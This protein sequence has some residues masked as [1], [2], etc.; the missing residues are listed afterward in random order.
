MAKMK[1]YLFGKVRIECDQRE[2]TLESQK[3]LELFC[4]LLLNQRYPQHR[5]TLAEVLWGDGSANSK[6]YLRKT[7]W[8]L[9]NFLG[10]LQETDEENYLLVD[11][12][13]IQINP[14]I[15]IWLDTDVFEYA[16]S[17]TVGI[18]SFDFTPQQ[19]QSTQEAVELYQADL[20]LGWQGNW[21]IFERERFSQLY[22][23][24]VDKLMGYCEAGNRYERGIEYG[25]EILRHDQAHERTHRRLMRLYYLAGDRTEALRQFN[26]CREILMDELEVEPSDRTLALYQ[27]IAEQQDVPQS[28]SDEPNERAGFNITSKT[29]SHIDDILRKQF[30]NHI[31]LEKELQK[32]KRALHLADN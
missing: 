20:L 28:L 29:L 4:Y 22:T 24:M 11:T 1:I 3:A 8:R 32:L 21:C 7:L 14:D 13:W 9:Q 25:R 2:H 30:H 15:D 31:S 17:K 10:E 6:N 5:D 27:I 18:H 19:F 16:Y 23:V 26:R 12:S